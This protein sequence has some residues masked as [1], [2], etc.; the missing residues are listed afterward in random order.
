MNEGL[1]WVFSAFILGIIVCYVAIGK[2]Q[3]GSFKSVEEEKQDPKDIVDNECDHETIDP[4]FKI[5]RKP[6]K[7]EKKEAKELYK[8][9]KPKTIQQVLPTEK[10]EM[11]N[12]TEIARKHGDELSLAIGERKYLNLKQWYCMSRPQYK[13]SCG[14]SSLTSIWN[15]LFSTLGHGDLPILTQE[16][17]LTLLGFSEP[18]HEIRFGPFCGNETIM[19]WFKELLSLFG[20]E[21]EACIF[22]KCKGLH[23]TKPSGNVLDELK[24]GLRSNQTAFIYHCYN[25]YM[26][27]MGFDESPT[28]PQHIY[29]SITNSEQV[30]NAW[31]LF[32]DNSKLQEP[33]ECAKFSDVEKDLNCEAPYFFN[34]RHPEKG[35]QKR[36]G[37][38]KSINVDCILRFQKLPAK[39]S[40]SQRTQFDKTRKK[41]PFQNICSGPPPPRKRFSFSTTSTAPLSSN[42]LHNKQHSTNSSNPSFLSY[43]TPES[44]KKQNKACSPSRSNNTPLCDRFISNRSSSNLRYGL[45]SPSIFD[46][47]S[48]TSSNS[49]S[50]RSV[51]T[52]FLRRNSFS[53][54]PREDSSSFTPPHNSTTTTSSSPNSSLS[55]YQYYQYNNNNNNHRITSPS[56]PLSRAG[57]GYSSPRSTTGHNNNNSQL[58]TT[59]PSILSDSSGRS[60][61]SLNNSLGSS[62]N[63]ST[64]YGHLDLSSMALE[65]GV[66][67]SGGGLSTLHNT[68][69]HSDVSSLNNSLQGV[70]PLNQSFSLNDPE[71]VDYFLQMPFPQTNLFST[72]QED[73]ADDEST[74][75]S[76]PS[77]GAPNGFNMDG[78]SVGGKGHVFNNLLI[79]ELLPNSQ[80]IVNTPYFPPSSSTTNYDS[81]FPSFTQ[82]HPKS[83]S[84]IHNMT[85]P[86]P[87]QRSLLQSRSVTSSP[88]RPKS[89]PTSTNSNILKFRPNSSNGIDISRRQA[90]HSNKGIPEPTLSMLIHPNNTILARNGIN[91]KTNQ[92][93][94]IS[95]GNRTIPDIPLRVL[96]APGIRDDF[97]LNLIDWGECNQIAVALNT[98][99]FLWNANNYAVS[100]LVSMNDEDNLVCSVSWMKTDPNVL[101]IGT[102]DGF[103]SI[104]DVQK[105]TKIRDVHRHAERVGSIS[106]NEY[107]IATGS[108]DNHIFISD[109]RAKNSLI[110][111]SGHSQEICGLQWNLKGNQIASG[112]NDN[113]LFVW[114]PG[115]NFRHP[116][117]KFNDHNAAVKAL[118]WSP[119]H[120]N[121]LVSGGGV[122]DRCLRFWNTSTGEMLSSRKTSSQI[123]NVYWS[124][125]TNELVTTHGFSQN[126]IT[127]WSCFPYVEPI[128]HLYGHTERVLFLTASPDGSQIVTG[129]GDETLRFWSLFT[130]PERSSS[131]MISLEI[132]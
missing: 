18:F 31:L 62:T 112:G 116:L 2:A 129:S 17:V 52:P 126:N 36:E 41:D 16:E 32:G 55:L 96:D 11:I 33:V 95:K 92:Q 70:N 59:P 106:W 25:H 42:S 28:H 60:N 107:Q 14:I 63:S 99:V 81:L 9:R 108:R 101:S 87:K 72:Y 98:S 29:Q 38:F 39:K 27:I 7:Q 125:Q 19:Q 66:V 48:N 49:S 114:E 67:N 78:V 40:S 89:S 64:S 43:R 111:L 21:G 103:V 3:N 113:N 44:S 73:I 26:V 35:I 56:R 82:N 20:M 61:N 5:S 37:K 83:S 109:I 80:S 121:L 86:Q 53:Y 127:V 24:K 100:N 71:S 119:N 84:S 122:K 68:T 85:H 1:V 45:S 105:Q 91:L 128:T 102:E 51:A 120:S 74:T 10:I 58:S 132:R 131:D 54:G 13:Y 65:D 124:K 94:V 47:L 90:Y 88:Q 6:T 117:W 4:R 57:S 79:S 23:T 30:S 118:A 15:Y 104:Y 50:S 115:F 110:K 123:C 97:Y 22:W 130:E 76:T 34:I 69:D 12:D 8:N 75:L 77:T 46:A 93:I